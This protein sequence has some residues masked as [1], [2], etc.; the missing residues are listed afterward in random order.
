MNPEE[1]AAP[2]A[3]E[4][5]II[6]GEIWR[7]FTSEQHQPQIISPSACFTLSQSWNARERVTIKADAPKGTHTKTRGRSIT[8]ALDRKPEAIARDITAR[9]LPH[10]LEYFTES[11][12]YDKEK[13]KEEAAANLKENF[14][15][16]FTDEKYNGKFYKK[17][18]DKDSR[19]WVD[20]CDY[21]NTAIIEIRL[22]FTK[23]VQLLK[24][25]TGVYI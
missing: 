4:L 19:L 15:K 24:H 22:P 14:I 25:I 23:A 10:A 1:L 17:S 6:T 8:C 9:L 12:N 16:Q 18:K 20:V 21:D 3:V 2:L 13:R 5:T 7:A 11:A